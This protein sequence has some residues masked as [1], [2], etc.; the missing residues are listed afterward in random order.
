MLVVPAL[1]RAHGAIDPEASVDLARITHVPTGLR[2]RMVDGDL[3]LWM[4]V[5]AATPVTVLDYQGGAY[6]RFSARGVYANQSSPMFYLNLNP[7]I[8]P[9]LTLTRHTPPT[10]HLV[11]GDHAY[12]WH[13]GRIAALA[14]DLSAPDARVLGRWTVPLLVGGHPETIGGVLLHRSRPSLAWLWPSVVA[15]LVLPAILRLRDS[16]L[17]RR[18][19]ARVSVATL[20]AVL[21]ASLGAGLHGRPGLSATLLVPMAVELALLAWAAVRLARRRGDLLTMALVAALALYRAVAG[22]AV[23]WR[24]YVLLAIP[25]T[26]ARVA[27][28]VCLA[29]GLY[30]AVEVCV[31]VDR[32]RPA[33]ARDAVTE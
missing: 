6:L 18:L 8:T 13:D 31:L 26:L 12:M 3:R 21:A 22:I 5:P 7:P 30:L 20:L 14:D 10:W 25:A 32:L 19:A 27:I 28:S 9:S 15:L 11:T 29:G 1:A 33:A 2:V 24:G 23:L 16:R 17:H 4:S